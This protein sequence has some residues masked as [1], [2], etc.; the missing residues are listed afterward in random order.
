MRSSPAMP[1]SRPAYGK[2]T[3]SWFAHRFAGLGFCKLRGRRGRTRTFDPQLRRLMLYPPELR[4]RDS[5]SMVAVGHDC[6]HSLNFGL[7]CGQPQQAS[8]GLVPL[9]FTH[10]RE[11]S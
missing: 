7:F 3:D 1:E 5:V 11:V 10:G 6:T 9:N 2:S 4:A 8:T